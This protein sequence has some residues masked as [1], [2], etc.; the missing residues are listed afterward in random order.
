[1]KLSNS[2]KQLAKII[3]ENGGWFDGANWA[4]QGRKTMGVGF[5]KSKPYRKGDG[6]FV[7][8]EKR[9]HHF[10]TDSVLPNW[11]QT[12]LHRDEYFHLYP[13]PDADGWIEWKSQFYGDMPVPEGTEVDIMVDGTVYHRYVAE[14]WKHWGTTTKYRLYKSTVAKPEPEATAKPTIEQLAADYRAKLAIAQKAQEEA[15]SHRCGAEAALKLLELAGAELGLVIGV[16]ETQKQETEL[17][18]TDW[19]DLRVGDEVEYLD[20]GVKYKIGM[21]GYID[22]FDENSCT[23]RFFRIKD[24]LNLGWP[25]KWRFIRRP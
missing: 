12:A 11:H 4:I 8:N 19:L 25:T 17:N 3:S 22:K 6:W 15:D 20:G 9:L 13:A 10:A 16:C 5:S 14:V 7:N 24:G 18:I 1:M 23:G 2:K 21:I